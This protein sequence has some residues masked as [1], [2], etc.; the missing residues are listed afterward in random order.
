MRPTLNV[1]TPELCAR[2]IAE[3]KRIM[4][5]TGM[6]IRGAGMRQRLLDSGLKTTRERRPRPVPT[7]SRRARDRNR[8]E[9]VHAL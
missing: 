7:G 9:V 4:A 3:A 1:I 6:D 8:A 5:E 2:V